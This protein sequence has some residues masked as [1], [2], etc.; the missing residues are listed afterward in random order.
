MKYL[1]L[2]KLFHT[3]EQKSNEIYSKRFDSESTHK[4]DIIINGFKCFYPINEEVLELI[5]NI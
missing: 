3:D 1:Q 4:L 5:G 2:K